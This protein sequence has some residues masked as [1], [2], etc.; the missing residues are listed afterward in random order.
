MKE[1]ITENKT[2]KLG[3]VEHAC[4]PSTQEVDTGGSRELLSRTYFKMMSEVGKR[5][6]L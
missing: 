4:N 3:M 6:R 1:A 5:L 2:R